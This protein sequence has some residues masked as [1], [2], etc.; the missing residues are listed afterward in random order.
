LFHSDPS[1]T[2]T[3]YKAKAIGSGSEGAQTSLQ[4]SYNESLTLA[5]AETLAMST[6]KAVMEEKLN[7]T[8]I[9]FCSVTAERGYQLYSK[10]ELLRVIA[11]L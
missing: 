9:E 6:L 2:F 5:E 10:E 4:E 11:T 8:N 7:E 3:K 1:G